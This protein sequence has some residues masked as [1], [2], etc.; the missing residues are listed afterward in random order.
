[1]TVVGMIGDLTTAQRRTDEKFN[2]LAE[3]HKR[4]TEAQA[5]TEE[6]LNIFIN[7]VERHLSNGQN[8]KAQ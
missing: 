8:G 5:E 2:E 4:L 7:I 6:R 1:M 3:S